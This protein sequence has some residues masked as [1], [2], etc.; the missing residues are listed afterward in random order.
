MNNTK[1]ITNLNIIK[2]VK[3]YPKFHSGTAV[4]AMLM[5]I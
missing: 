5:V 3:S 1:I 2:Y 4:D